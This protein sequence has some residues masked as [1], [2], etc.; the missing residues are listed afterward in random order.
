MAYIILGLLT[1]LPQSL[2]ELTKNFETGVS[3]I[4]SSSTGSIKRALDRLLADGKIRIE[5]QDGPRGKK[6]YTITDTGRADF[7]RWM[8]DE[9]L[10]GDPETAML[11]RA[12]FLGLLPIMERV[13]V[14]S[15]IREQLHEGLRQLERLEARIETLNVPEDFT[16]VAHYQKATL[17]YGLAWYRSTLAWAEEHLP[18]A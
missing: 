6:T 16:A 4:Y 15:N 10:P 5:S 11:S 7:R 12:H 2:Y 1:L 14:A 18:S 17:Q 13:Q 3:L 9:T 8:L